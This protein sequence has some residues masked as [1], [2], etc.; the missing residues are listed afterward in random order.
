VELAVI[1]W[2]GLRV[3]DVVRMAGMKQS[4]RAVSDMYYKSAACSGWKPP[5]HLPLRDAVC[6]QRY[7]RSSERGRRWSYEGKPMR[8]Q[9]VLTPNLSRNSKLQ[10]MHKHGPPSLGEAAFWPRFI[11]DRGVFMD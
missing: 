5:A 11:G 3:S 4:T 6:E 7:L 8:I 1:V 10:L 2:H 9:I